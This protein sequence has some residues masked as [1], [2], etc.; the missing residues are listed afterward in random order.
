MFGV[1]ENGLEIAAVLEDD[2]CPGAALPE[3][4]RAI[5]ASGAVFDFIDLHRKFRDEGSDF[6]G[7]LKLWQFWRDAQSL[8]RNY[9]VAELA[10]QLASSASLT[11][12]A[13]YQLAGGAAAISAPAVN[14]AASPAT[15]N[16]FIAA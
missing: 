5:E 3:V 10:A 2:A 7:Y 4:L 13:T 12:V 14:V 6:V 11:Y 16:C 1:I 9:L 15:T 8:T